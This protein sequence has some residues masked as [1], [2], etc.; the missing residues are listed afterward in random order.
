MRFR[1]RQNQR[2]RGDRQTFEPRRREAGRMQHQPGIDIVPRQRFDLHVTGRLDQFQRHLRTLEA[3]IAH[4]H[5][6]TLETD[7]RY[8]GQP[9]TPDLTGCG[10]TRTQGKRLRPRQHVA[11]VGQ[12]RFTGGG[13]RNAALRTV[14][15]LHAE[16]FLQLRD[17][18]RHRRLRHVQTTSGAPE[19]QFFGDCDE[20]P[21]GTEIDERFFHP[22]RQ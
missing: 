7:G 16:R 22:Q 18:L 11:H 17:G 21:P 10:G 2:F 3:E 14:E 13:E 9:H 6:Q 15:Q 5:R 8:E 20:L 4:P 1:Q 12:Q 19:V